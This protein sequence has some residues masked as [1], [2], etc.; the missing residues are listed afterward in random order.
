MLMMRVWPDLRRLHQGVDPDVVDFEV[1]GKCSVVYPLLSAPVAA[2]G[3]IDQPMEPFV[4]RPRLVSAAFVREFKKLDIVDVTPNIV[5]GPVHSVAMKCR[6]GIFDLSLCGFLSTDGVMISV[7]MY[8][9]MHNIRVV[10]H[11]LEDVDLTRRRPPAVC[12]VRRKHPDSRPRPTT[13]RNFGAHFETAVQEVPFTAAHQAGG[14]IVKPFVPFLVGG[15]G[16]DTIGDPD[17]VRPVFGVILQFVIPPAVVFGP[18]V[19]A[20]FAFIGQPFVVE[21]VCPGRRLCEG[22]HDRIGKRIRFPVPAV[23]GHEALVVAEIQ[24]FVPVLGDIPILE[25]AP[26]L[27]TVVIDDFRDGNPMLGGYNGDGAE[28]VNKEEATFHKRF[29]WPAFAVRFRRVQR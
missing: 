5:R 21:L 3:E 13:G 23:E 22:I 2:D 4:K 27:I 29:R 15:D 20:P 7:G 28:Q 14:G 19:V 24:D 17:I 8:G 9:N 10:S 16:E 6:H 18:D 25:V 1:R 12:P 26:V 11:M